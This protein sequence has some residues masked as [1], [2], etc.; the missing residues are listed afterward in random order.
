MFA[1]ML[2]PGQDNSAPSS[3]ILKTASFVVSCGFRLSE[4]GFREILNTPGLSDDRRYRGDY[5]TGGTLREPKYP[6]ITVFEYK[7]WVRLFMFFENY[8]H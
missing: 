7:R 6:L 5:I 3:P 4:V 1:T 2:L 8:I